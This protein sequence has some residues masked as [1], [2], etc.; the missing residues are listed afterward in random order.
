MIC[1]Y[2]TIFAAVLGLVFGSF[3][4][5]CA[6]RWPEDESAVKPR[7]HCRSCN[8][9]LAW[10]ENIP[11]LSWLALR[12]R[13][14]SCNKPIGFRYLL[15]EFSVGALWAFSTWKIFAIAPELNTGVLTANSG[16]AIAN[17]IA[18]MVF[19]WIL[20]ALAVLDAEN[21]WLPDRLTF[22]GIGLGLVLA[23]TLATFITFQQFNGS[24]TAW[25]HL[26]AQYIVRMW[27]IGAVASAGVLIVIRIAYQ[28]FRGQE[29]IGIGDI[30]LMAMLGG[31]LGAKCALLALGFGILFGALAVS[32]IFAI[33]AMRA[34]TKDWKKKQLPFGTFICLGGIIAAFWGDPIIAAYMSW[35][36]F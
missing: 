24:F 2:A 36:G 23:T 13:C 30:K 18:R 25:V 1:T 21:L 22:T 7:S 6:S 16:E 9:T 3:L 31:W 15:V 26:A 20:V 32:T 4:N 28:F 14:R 33:P 29:G 17:G 5:T 27:F 11:L 34:N 19:L 35:G 10:W 12:G 8:R